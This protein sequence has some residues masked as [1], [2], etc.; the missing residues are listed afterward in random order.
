MWY[1]ILCWY[2]FTLIASIFR[3]TWTSIIFR[4]GMIC[5]WVV[6]TSF[7]IVSTASS[8]RFYFVKFGLKS[9]AFIILGYVVIV[10]RFFIII[11]VWVIV[12][13]V[14]RSLII[15]IVNVR[16]IPVISNLAG[17][18]LFNRSSLFSHSDALCLEILLHS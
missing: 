9:F 17:R 4:L 2:T 13:F 12:I 6:T 16:S 10:M 1:R 15:I 3:S 11:I 14:S 7:P 5:F 18:S 8:N